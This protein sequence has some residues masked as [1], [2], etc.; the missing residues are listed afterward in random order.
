MTFGRTV[1][2]KTYFYGDKSIFSFR[3][4][5]RMQ[6]SDSFFHSVQLYFQDAQENPWDWIQVPLITLSTEKYFFMSI[7][8]YPLSYNESLS[9]NGHDFWTYSTR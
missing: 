3:V 8:S 1:Q 6:C 2:D 9:K 7:K 4:H 5:L